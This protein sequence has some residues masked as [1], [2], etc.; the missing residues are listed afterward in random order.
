VKCVTWEMG[1]KL[2]ATGV[3]KSLNYIPC[4][5]EEK[6]PL[7]HFHVL[8]M[9]SLHNTLLHSMNIIKGTLSFLRRMR[10]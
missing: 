7:N 5:L 1:R 6:R 9:M 4:E 10:A 2:E 3:F 8:G